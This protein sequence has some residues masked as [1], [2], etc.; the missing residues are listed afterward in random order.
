MGMLDAAIRAMSEPVADSAMVPTWCLSRMAA[1]DGVKVLLSGT[2]G[3]EVFAG[4]PRYVAS[5]W[6]RQLL[7]HLPAALRSMAGLALG[8]GVLGARLRHPALDMSIY[9]GGSP[10]L[11]ASVLPEG[12]RLD[13]FLDRVAEEIHPQPQAGLP[14]LYGHMAFD[15][16][17]YLPDLLLLLLD[18]LTMA[19]TLEGR[20]P[21]LD[22]DLVAA[23]F[24]LQPQLHA[25]PRRA[26]TRKLMRRMARGRLDERTLSGAKQGF[27]GPVR[28]WIEANRAAFRDRTMAARELPGLERLRPEEWWRDG[29]ERSPYWAQEVFL[30]YCFA[31]WHEAHVGARG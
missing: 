2:G 19:H 31:T 10:S 7:Y 27:S 12:T 11:A 3:D 5:S 1:E 9:T 26:E 14:P 21:L 15:L 29:A 24:A 22:V 4:Y 20:V 25:D 13:A 17:V 16:Q 23:S 18:Q 6:R 8:P 30:L 28:S